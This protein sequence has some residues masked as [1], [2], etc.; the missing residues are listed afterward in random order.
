MYL[1]AYVYVYVRM[2]MYVCVCVIYWEQKITEYVKSHKLV[3]HNVLYLL[4]QWLSQW[5]VYT[6]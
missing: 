5:L 3:K 6:S 1:R 4:S 2:C